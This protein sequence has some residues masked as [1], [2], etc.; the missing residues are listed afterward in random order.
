MLLL[1]D[2]CYMIYQKCTTNI[3]LILLYD[4]IKKSTT[5]IV[6]LLYDILQISYIVEDYF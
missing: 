5:I 3:V 2:Y 4:I 1:L 6:L